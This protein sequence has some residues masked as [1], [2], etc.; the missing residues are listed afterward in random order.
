MNN[1][2]TN[3]DDKIKRIVEKSAQDEGMSPMSPPDYFNAPSKIEEIPYDQLPSPIKKLVDEHK[4]AIEQL[5]KF[6]NA[7]VEFK[8]SGFK[9]TPELSKTF[10]EFFEFFDNELIPH[11]QKEDKFLFPVLEKYLLKSGEHSKYMSNNQY[12]TSVDVME[13]DHLKMLQVGALI[14]NL[15]GIYVR[16]PDTVSRNLIADFVFNKGMELIDLLRVHIYQEENIL[17]PQSVKFLSEEEFATISKY[18]K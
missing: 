8:E 12:E 1:M 7:L 17:F 5:E 18:I 14:F 6:Q 15:L 4:V 9:Y 13:D 11:H 16:I 3:T 2:T 10:K